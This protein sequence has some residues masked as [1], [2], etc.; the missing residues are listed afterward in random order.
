MNQ[1]AS[2]ILVF[3]IGS[4]GDTIVALPAFEE[5]RRQHPTSKIT[6]L[7]NRD[8]SNPERVFAAQVVEN[9]G[10]FD[11]YL[12]YPSNAAGTKLSKELIKLTLEIRSRKYD[13]LYY[14]P[15][16]VRTLS[17][18]KRDKLF[19][20]LCGIKAFLGFE[21]Y[22]NRFLD[23]ET[24]PKYVSV[25]KEADFLLSCIEG[26]LK[27]KADD[28]ASTTFGETPDAIPK[29]SL[30][31]E[32]IRQAVE[33]IKYSGVKEGSLLIA[34]CPGAKWQ[35]KIWPIENY[36]FVIRALITDFDITPL[37]FGDRT[38]REIGE[39][40]IKDLGRGVNYAGCLTIRE[41][42]S[43]ISKTT[44]YLGNDT[45]TMHLAAA[46]GV[47]CVAVFA[48]IDWVG[49]WHPAGIGHT[50]FRTKVDCEVCMLSECPFDNL[51]MKKIDAE[52]VLQ[53]CRER[54]S[55]LR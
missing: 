31:N 42:A 18:Q 29:I 55:G 23:L 2:K 12:A 41:S 30:S 3:R 53:A 10:I 8:L 52:S 39:R 38:E 13:L 26:S 35:S 14:L 27:G 25:E 44:L 49:R 7:S 20:R 50:V 1:R 36:I 43:V 48:S 32:E 15:P 40:L 9:N 37:I 22:K 24:T 33:R 11:D 19:F 34:V 6:L 17:Q 16:R 21:S 4:L 51:C 54:L 46:V 47:P 28:S 45:G 5:I